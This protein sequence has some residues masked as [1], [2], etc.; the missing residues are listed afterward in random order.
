MTNALSTSTPNGLPSGHQKKVLLVED[1]MNYVRPIKRWLKNEGYHVYSASSYQ[2]AK[3]ALD[4]G[5]FHAAVIDINLE[6]SNADNQ[7][8]LKL[9][10]DIIKAN[11]N[12][13]MPCVILTSHATRENI[14]LATQKYKARF[15]LKD[16]QYGRELKDELRRIFSEEIQI[17]FDLEYEVDC[18]Q[19][20]PKIAG[21]IKWEDGEE[22]HPPADQ[23][24]EQIRDI[25]GKLFY[26]ASRLYIRKLKP[27]LTGAA[28]LRAEPTG[29]HGITPPQVVKV[30]RRDKTVT[31]SENYKNY[32]KNYLPLAS[33]QANAAYSQHLGG[34]LYTFMGNGTRS[35][36]E[37]DQ[38]YDEENAET[39]IKSLEDLI[40]NTCR[41]W[42]NHRDRVRRDLRA[43]YYKALNLD[44]AKL[45][46]RIGSV[47]PG[48]DPA[49]KHTLF[50]P[51]HETIINP[52]QWMDDRGDDFVQAVFES[53]THGDLTGRNIMVDRDKGCWL[54]DF[55]RT[56]PSHI[57]RDFLIL[58]TD[59]KYRMLPCPSLE[60]FIRLEKTLFAGDFS[61]RQ[62]QV[63]EDLPGDIQKAA[64]VVHAL[65]NF[66]TQIAMGLGETD[67]AREEY[68]RSLLMVTLNVVRL[69]HIE[70]ERKLHAL[71]SAHLICQEIDR[72]NRR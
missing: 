54:I 57:L 33:V 18:D 1:D 23:L 52:L 35:F 14:L 12:A 13:L 11:L 36:A 69:R 19:L 37:F 20:L 7:D 60:A 61:K 45:I 53:I 39:I 71:Y 30:G 66:A 32:V 68:L 62:V 26:D 31:E 44:K 46:E 21:E 3:R 41:Y 47:L 56:Y 17:N 24:T 6:I 28:V 25:F 9:F 58:E 50:P 16:P 63:D 65:H 51:T 5:H 27:G 15:L 40:F 70:N 43:L 55:Y 72:L 38:F 34:V 29:M 10:P 8:G 4:G 42:Y 67:L 48:Y 59:I 2:E 49:N 22:N 64:Q